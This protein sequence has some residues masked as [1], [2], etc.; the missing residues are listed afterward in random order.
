[1]NG[2]KIIMVLFIVVSASLAEEVAFGQLLM[3]YYSGIGIE[4]LSSGGVNALALAFFNPAPLGNNQNC[5]FTNL[6]TPCLIPATGSGDGKNLKWAS[7]IIAQSTAA[8]RG[9]TAPTR[10]GK[11]TIFFSF[12]GQ[13]QGGAVWDHLLG[14][15][16]AIATTFGQNAAKLATTVY[17]AVGQ[18]VYIGI[19]LDVEGTST[20]LPNIGAFVRAFRATAPYGT[21]PLQLCTLSGLASPNSA[22]YFKVAIMQQYGPSTQGINYLNMMVNNVDSSCDV[23]SAFWR[24]PT[25]NFLPAS[26]K[27]LGVWGQ[28]IPSWVLH[29]PGCTDGSSPLF[30]WIKQNGVGVGIWQWWTGGTTEIS[31]FLNQIRQA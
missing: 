21:F 17:N 13:S 22:D 1:M 15:S 4:T 14:G 12:G 16:A 10:G 29:N 23:M 25:L 31:A 6:N 30:P 26:S 9:N 5:D 20:T 8:L 11:P 27:I 19:D 7:D 3:A 28:I 18:T 24:H 2:R